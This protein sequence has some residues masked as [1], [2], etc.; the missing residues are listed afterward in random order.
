MV[1]E[2]T[3]LKTLTNTWFTELPDVDL[4]T[5]CT[6]RQQAILELPQA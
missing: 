1:L 5:L 3:I 4:I 6:Q 2:H